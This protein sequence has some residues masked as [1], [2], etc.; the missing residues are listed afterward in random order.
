MKNQACIQ[1][2]KKNIYMLRKGNGRMHPKLVTMGTSE[3]KREQGEGE[4]GYH[5]FTLYTYNID[6]FFSF[7]NA[8]TYCLQNKKEKGK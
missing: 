2:K 5:G 3:E 8:F 6:F 4:E 7:K 1:K